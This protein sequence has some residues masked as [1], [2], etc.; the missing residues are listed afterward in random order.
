L[1]DGCSVAM[2]SS[3][4]IPQFDVAP[5]SNTAVPFFFFSLSV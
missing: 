3:P 1:F 4:V 2:K 5:V